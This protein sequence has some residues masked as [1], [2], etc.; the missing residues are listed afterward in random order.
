M[1]QTSIVNSLEN[2]MTF[3]RLRK[4]VEHGEIA[5]HGAYFGI[6]AG[7]LLIR[8]PATGVFKP[9]IGEKIER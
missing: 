3:P 2:L 6:A 5:L 4:R 8:D 7:Q 1:E 9:A